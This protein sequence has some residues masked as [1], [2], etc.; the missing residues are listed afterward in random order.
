MFFR[1]MP[2]LVLMLLIAVG[3][4][5]VAAIGSV[6]TGGH[7]LGATEP[8]VQTADDLAAGNLSILTAPRTSDDELPAAVAASAA[9]QIPYGANVHLSH[10]V[11]ADATHVVYAVP[12]RDFTCLIVPEGEGATTSCTSTK[13]IIGGTAAPALILSGDVAT[14]YAVVPDG[15]KSVT[16]HT[17]DG[18]ATDVPVQNGGYVVSVPANASPET[19]SYDSASGPVSE[20]V[21]VPP[22]APKVANG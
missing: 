16:L 5:S 10:R 12:A 17:G 20:R 7:A 14:L 6:S 1:K 19:I 18:K 21:P 3:V 4:A 11:A 15:V 22:V 9:S 13:D 8:A 2:F